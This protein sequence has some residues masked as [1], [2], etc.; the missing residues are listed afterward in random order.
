MVK[1]K[2]WFPVLSMMFAVLLVLTACTGGGSS[3]SGDDSGGGTEV[4]S[5]QP[6]PA[7]EAESEAEPDAEPEP[8]AEPEEEEP[9]VDMQGRPVR[10]ASWGY[11]GGSE[12]TA[13]GEARIATEKALGEKYNTELQFEVIPWGDIQNNITASI[14]A[15]EP[16]ADVFLL[17]RYR[18][19]PSMVQNDLLEPIDEILSLDDP[20]YPWPEKMREIGSYNGKTYGFATG[21]GAGGGIYYNK[22]IFA[23]EGLP[24]PHELVDKGEWTWE[25]FLD[26]AKR[27]TKDTD[28]DG[29]IDQYGLA[30]SPN[31]F[32]PAFMASNGADFTRMENGKLVFDADSKNAMEVA[33]F[34]NDLFNVHKVVAP[35][36]SGEWMYYIDAFNEGNIAMRYG[37]A[38]EGGGIRENL[39]ND[40]AFVYIPIGPKMD[41]YSN[42]LANVSFWFVPKGADPD[43]VRIYAEYLW[44]YAPEP[45]EVDEY[46]E[47]R[48]VD[49]RSLEIYLDMVNYLTAL[50]WQG[51]PDFAPTMN[52]AFNK[53]ARGEETPETAIASVKPVAEGLL[54]AAQQ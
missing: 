14:I 32:I 33:H 22:A 13:E 50:D 16:I 52:E 23:K 27:A 10:I 7:Q 3:G 28:G 36:E 20:K 1:R 37:E 17:D 21:L 9:A 5:N 18:A 44:S 25:T 6:E 38:W 35:N 19:F 42:A 48:F 45:G 41:T 15:G 34:W 30:A 39:G 47:S 51:I 46:T 8:E 11:A 53:I 31:N 29:K 4:S 26:I 24:D 43:A 49:E 2:T 12:D 40:Y 54:D